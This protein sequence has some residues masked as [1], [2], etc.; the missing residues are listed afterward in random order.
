MHVTGN[1]DR[2]SLLADDEEEFDDEDDDDDDVKA[3]SPPVASVNEEFFEYKEDE[4]DG[5]DSNDSQEFEVPWRPPFNKG[6]P[7]SSS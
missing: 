3:D 2:F 5:I 4:D 6:L 7:S 1:E